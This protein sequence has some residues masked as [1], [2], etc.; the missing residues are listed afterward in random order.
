M[1]GHMNVKH[2][3]VFTYTRCLSTISHFSGTVQV[4]LPLYHLQ[5]ESGY[6]S[7]ILI[8]VKMWRQQSAFILWQE[9]QNAF[10]ISGVR[11]GVNET[12]AL[13]GCYAAYIVVIR[14]SFGTTCRSHFQGSRSVLELWKLL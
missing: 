14:R 13:L 12:F 1:H 8:D 7:L 9:A 6:S 2:T 5:A 10:V 3:H 11:R 4:S